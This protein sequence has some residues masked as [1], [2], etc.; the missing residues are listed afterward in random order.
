MFGWFKKRD[1]KRLNEIENSVRNSFQNMK[2]DMSHVSQW[3]GHFKEK[4][5]HHET[6]LNTHTQEI[7]NLK[8]RIEALESFF[9][10][11]E[12]QKVRVQEIIETENFPQLDLSETKSQE[13]LLTETQKHVFRILSRLVK[14][15]PDGWV[16]LKSLAGDAYPNNEY[17][18]IR[19][20]VS[21]FVTVLELNGYVKRKRVGKEMFVTVMKKFPLVETNLQKV[22][23]RKSSKK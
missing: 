4:H 15:N 22:T 5:G 23:A 9:E 19:S 13:N 6:K 8:K 7:E 3:I 10:M 18:K 11:Q 12:D 14:E 21:Q 2:A 16:S 20:A 1:D 17:H